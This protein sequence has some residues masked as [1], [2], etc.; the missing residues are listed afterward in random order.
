MA[1]NQAKLGRLLDAY[2]AEGF[3]LSVLDERKNR[4]T[5]HGLELE[6]E[7]A[8]LTAQLE[9]QP[10]ID[11]QIADVRESA[12]RIAAGFEHADD[13]FAFRR[14]IIEALDVRA[15]LTLEGHQRVVYAKCLLGIRDFGIG[16]RYN[17]LPRINHKNGIPL[18]ARLVSVGS[19]YAPDYVHPQMC[20]RLATEMERCETATGDSGSEP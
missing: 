19:R 13:D 11:A 8:R 16:S 3:P 4:L 12:A 17:P 15:V 9:E 1:D 6:L 2:L 20:K 5:A 18:S 14:S 10:L 7:R